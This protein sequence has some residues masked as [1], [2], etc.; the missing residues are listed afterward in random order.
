METQEKEEEN[1]EELSKVVGESLVGRRTPAGN[2]SP[3]T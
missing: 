3:N 1:N 2:N